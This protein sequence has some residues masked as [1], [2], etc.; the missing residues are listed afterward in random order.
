MTQNHWMLD[1]LV[2]LQSFAAANG[3]GSLADQLDETLVIA[4]AELEILDDTAGTWT[5]GPQ[6]KLEQSSEN[7]GGHKHT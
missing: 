7:S 5:N 4:S 3:L 1:V 6:N 2:D